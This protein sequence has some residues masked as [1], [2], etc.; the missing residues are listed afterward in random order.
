LSPWTASH[1]STEL[2]PVLQ[3][4]ELTTEH[5]PTMA[6]TGFEVLSEGR[7]G[8]EWIPDGQKKGGYDAF[9][10]FGQ[11]WNRGATEFQLESLEACAAKCSNMTVDPCHFFSY[12]KNTSSRSSSCRLCGVCNLNSW[13]GTYSS[14]T[15]YK[16]RGTAYVRASRSALITR[17]LPRSEIQGDYSTELYGAPGRAPSE[18]ELRV[19]WLELLSPAALLK[20][21]KAR[22]CSSRGGVPDRPFFMP[23]EYHQSLLWLHQPVARFKPV[24]AHSWVE[25]LHCAKRSDAIPVGAPRFKA[26]PLWAYATPGSGVSMNVGHT[27]VV[28]SFREASQILERLFPGQQPPGCTGCPCDDDGLT[29]ANRSAIA[30]WRAAPYGPGMVDLSAID[31]LQIVNHLE[32]FSAEP[33]HEIVFLRKL[34]CQGLE[35]Y[36]RPPHRQLGPLAARAGRQGDAEG[37]EGVVVCGRWPN[38]T[39]CSTAA[40]KRISDCHA[41]EWTGSWGHAA[42]ML[43]GTTERLQDCRHSPCYVD[44]EDLFCPAP[45]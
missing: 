32:Y 22:L 3:P 25:I 24:P 40:M 8:C 20:L 45:P 21:G 4:V 13:S 11:Q 9:V 44:G 16:R 2:K 6:P 23:M 39:Q 26:T 43:T 42:M 12:S 27:M 34:E 19:V 29:D 41:K 15:T 35:A 38:F 1:P 5:I 31:S 14:Y 33:R 10:G 17:V 28:S 18:L 7:A 36:M 30:A 37:G